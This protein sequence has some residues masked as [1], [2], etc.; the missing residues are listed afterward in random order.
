[1]IA[2]D[3]FEMANIEMLRIAARKDKEETEQAA[4]SASPA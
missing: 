1:M 4:D 2:Q 3:I